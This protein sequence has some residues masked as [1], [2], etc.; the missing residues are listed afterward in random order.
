MN[1]KLFLTAILLVATLIYPQTREEILSKIKSGEIPVS[2]DLVKQIEQK[3]NGANK[4]QPAPGYVVAPVD[5]TNKDKKIAA[6]S[7]HDAASNRDLRSEYKALVKADLNRLQLKDFGFD[8]FAQTMPQAVSTLAPSEDYVINVGDEVIVYTWGRENGQKSLFVDKDGFFNYPPLAPIRVAGLSFRDARNSIKSSLENISGLQARISLGQLSSI[9]V[10]LLGDVIKPGSYLVTSGTTVINALFACG[11]IKDIGSLR[12][13][14]L[15]RGGKPFRTIDLYNLLLKGSSGN[16]IQLIAGDVV[17]VPVAE[18]RVGVA[19]FVKR[20]ALYEAKTGDKVSDLIKYAGGLS[21]E[22]NAGRIVVERYKQNE[23]RVVL[24]FKMNSAT[25]QIASDVAVENGDLIKVFPLIAD[26]SNGVVVVGHVASPGKYEYRKGLTVKSILPSFQSY[27]PETFFEYAVV[28]RVFL[29]D[30]HYEFVPFSLGKIYNDGVDFSLE[31]RDTLFVYSRKELTDLAN[32][33]VEGNVRKPGKIPY[34]QNM[35]VSDAIVS[36]GGFSDDTY[37]DEAQVIS[38]QNGGNKA[39]IKR[40]NLRKILEDYTTPDNIPLSLN[41]R[42][43]VFSKWNFTFR[44]SVTIHGEVK[45]PG[46]FALASGM[47]VDD[48]VKQAGGYTQATYRLYVEIVRTELLRDSI[49]KEKVVKLNFDRVPEVGVGFALQ[50]RDEVFIRNIIDYG[51]SIAVRLNG[52]FVFPGTYR[53]EKGENI[54]SII[55]RAG[56]FRDD[57]YLPG[58]IFTR[59]RVQERQ[60]ENLKKVADNLEKQLQQLLTQEAVGATAEDKAYRDLLIQQQMTMLENMR[61]SVPLGRVVMKIDN[62]KEFKGSEN[63]IQV[64]DGDEIT[65]SENLNTVSILGE[66]YAPISVVY[67]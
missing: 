63:D 7:M 18:K 50:P 13:I 64:E 14:R 60:Q 25:G 33:E 11:G 38:H 45:K 16:D 4:N 29:P 42:V 48:L 21:A 2:A 28:K 62:W 23:K 35:R 44:D 49:E 61:S 55:Q 27:L 36:A 34:I 39:E 22:A 20:P 65:V 1:K 57:A 37:L 3:Q 43:I 12:Q 19:G 56:G 59:K 31:P 52:R 46:T 66:V 17:F 40:V 32:V 53:A 41:D 8:V 9:R 5:S 15:E 30:Y 47:S 10:L 67:S 26:E 58:I 6:D 24:D 51:K 54:S